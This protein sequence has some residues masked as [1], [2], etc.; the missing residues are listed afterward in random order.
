[1]VNSMAEVFAACQVINASPA[2]VMDNRVCNVGAVGEL[3]ILLSISTG[4]LQLLLVCSMLCV[5]P[6]VCWLVWLVEGALL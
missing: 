6:R 3:I 5:T 4:E 2:P 1:M